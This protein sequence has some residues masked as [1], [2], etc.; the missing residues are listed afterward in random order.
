[1]SMRPHRDM[2]DHFGPP[3]QVRESDEPPKAVIETVEPPTQEEARDNRCH[4]LDSSYVW[5]IDF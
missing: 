5:K 1:M 2:E 3:Q 4:Y